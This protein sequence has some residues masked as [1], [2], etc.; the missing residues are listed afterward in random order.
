MNKGQTSTF[1]IELPSRVDAGQT[2]RLRARLEAARCFYNTVV[3]EALT[4]LKQ[5]RCY[6]PWQAARAIPYT[7]KQECV[8]AF[9]RLR[10]K[11]RFSEDDLHAYAKEARYTWIAD[12]LD[13]TMAQTLA[14]RAYQAYVVI[15]HHG[16]EECSCVQKDEGKVALQLSAA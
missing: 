1:L 6:H 5:I 13:S 8:T 11:Y 14:T 2:H 4:R 9:A 15:P 12:H 10:C 7:Q 16:K 3:G